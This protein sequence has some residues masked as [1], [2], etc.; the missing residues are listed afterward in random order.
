MADNLRLYGDNIERQ[1]YMAE[2]A[3][4]NGIISDW[5]NQTELSDAMMLLGLKEWKNE[6]KAANEAFNTRYLERTQQYGAATDETI[7]SE[8]A[9]TNQL[10]YDLHDQLAAHNIVAK[11]DQLTKAIK[12][13]NALIAQHNVLLHNR[14]P[15]PE[16]ETPSE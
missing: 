11:S 10:Y 4:L 12:E 1:N 14:A 5:E 3:T 8:K 6:L 9:E 7:S 15:E 13:L 2:T 16:N